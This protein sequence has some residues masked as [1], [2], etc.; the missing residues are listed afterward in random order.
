MCRRRWLRDSINVANSFWKVWVSFSAL[1]QQVSFVL[2]SRVHHGR[3][4]GKKRE[5]RMYNK[6][7]NLDPFRPQR[8]LNRLGKLGEIFLHNLGS[9]LE[10][11]RLEASIQIHAAESMFF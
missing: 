9:I 10:I 5:G 7:I 11:F 1:L 8:R 6:I 4:K 2:T 3:I